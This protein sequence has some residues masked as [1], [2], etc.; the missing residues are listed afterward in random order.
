MRESVPISIAVTCASATIRLSVP[1]H[2]RLSSHAF[3][4][5]EG[6]AG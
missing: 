3:A 5:P 1:F 4:S 2:P 6:T